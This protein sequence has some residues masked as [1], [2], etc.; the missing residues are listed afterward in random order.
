MP[1]QQYIT[2]FSPEA[3][4]VIKNQ[5]ITY[6][7]RKHFIDALKQ[8]GIKAD[9]AYLQTYTYEDITQKLVNAFQNHQEK[10]V[11]KFTFMTTSRPTRDDLNEIQQLIQETLKVDLGMIYNEFDLKLSNFED[12][13]IILEMKLK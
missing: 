7:R 6:R 13:G 8:K 1:E 2:T 12:R 11:V 9:D 3:E 5:M 4:N 10:I